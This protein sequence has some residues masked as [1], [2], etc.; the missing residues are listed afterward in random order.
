MIMHSDDYEILVDAISWFCS[1]LSICY[2]NMTRRRDTDLK[3]TLDINHRSRVDEGEALEYADE[4]TYI[5]K[6]VYAI[7]SSHIRVSASGV[8]PYFT[9]PEEL[10]SDEA[11][12]MYRK[13]M[14]DLHNILKEKD[15]RFIG[16]KNWLREVCI[17]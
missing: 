8:Q 15:S 16:L 7:N 1:D 11:Y 4:I 3:C 12:A 10:N 2:V 14:E 13:N 9:Y 6:L 17:D 5:V